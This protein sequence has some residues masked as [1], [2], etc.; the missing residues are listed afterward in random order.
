MSVENIQETVT[1]LKKRIQHIGECLDIPE[2]RMKIK[3][4]E[5]LSL[6]KDFWND[7]D[8][9]REILQK[10]TKYSDA[11]D[12]WDKFNKDL[13][14]IE[15]LTEIAL[16]EKDE[17]VL[18]DIS[19]DLE[20]LNLAVGQEELK[21]MLNSEQDAMNAIV[22]IHA[23]AGGTEAQDWTEMLLRMYL[24]W[25]E[26]RK[27][28]TKIIDFL[29]GDEAGVKS[30]SFTIEG[31]YAYGY[32][33]AESGIHRLVRISPFDAGAR[34]HTSF[35][36]VFVYPEVDDEIK[37]DINDDDLRIDTF[38]AGGKGGQHVNKTDS[39]VRI[40]H[41]PTGIVVQCQNERSQFQNKA[42]AMKF[43]KSRLYERELQLKNEKID[44]ENKLKKDIAWGSQIR[45]YVLHPY[46]MVKDHRTNLETGN[47]GKVLDGDIDEFI[48]AYL[49]T[50]T[51][52]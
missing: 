11:V 14:D 29:A 16:Q 43:L 13:I 35:A 9:A 15:N 37:I 52:K 36:S 48:Q 34:R 49:M 2:M 1:D 44:E 12:R 23:G 42:M 51:G 17:P 22:S 32:A 8:K 21:M 33:K 31:E 10:K 6:K 20:Q 39:A 50:T 30:V 38:R 7:Q 3:D 45:S 19:A 4:L 18:D 25:A 24:R 28:A 26:K 41:L 47:A 40:T 5:E 46:K 27:F